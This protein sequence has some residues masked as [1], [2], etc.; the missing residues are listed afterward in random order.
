[1]IHT[2]F[3]TIAKVHN[4]AWGNSTSHIVS[5]SLSHAAAVLCKVKDSLWVVGRWW[6]PTLIDCTHSIAFNLSLSSSATVRSTLHGLFETL[7]SHGI[8]SHSLLH[9]LQVKSPVYL[10]GLI[11]FYISITCPKTS[12]A[13][14]G[15]TSRLG[16]THWICI[17]ASLCD[18]YITMTTVIFR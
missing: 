5:V 3:T 17:L 8:T 9:Q 18:D 10:D 15:G 12:P 14:R 13:T 11:I 1:M 6:I 16:P 7:N 2:E 4:S